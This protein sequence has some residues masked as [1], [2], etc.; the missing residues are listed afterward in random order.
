MAQDPSDLNKDVTDSV[1]APFPG[2]AGT[3]ASGEQE[4]SSDDRLIK[5]DDFLLHEYDSLRTEILQGIS[6]RYTIITVTLTAFGAAFVIQNTILPLL[7]PALA[8]VMMNIYIA[9]SYGTRKVTEFVKK[10]IETQVTTDGT[11]AVTRSELSRIGWQAHRD[12]SKSEQELRNRYSAGKAVF[13]VSSLAASIAGWLFN[14]QAASSA[15]VWPGFI[16]FSFI[17][18]M[19]LAIPAFFVSDDTLVRLYEQRPSLE[20][21]MP[22]TK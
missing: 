13:F 4:V 20:D 18:S 3:T 12:D 9:N 22:L 1:T 11:H 21:K 2:D 19:L 5:K 14:S 10:H 8:L 16:V 6:T 7:F 17:I 15:K